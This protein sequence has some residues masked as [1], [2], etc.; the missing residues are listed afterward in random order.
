MRSCRLPATSGPHT[1][2]PSSYA[3]LTLPPALPGLPWPLELVEVLVTIMKQ[4][5]RIL[6]IQLCACSLLLR[7]LGGGGCR[8]GGDPLGQVGAELGVC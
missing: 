2:P 4:H 6:D 7:I 3:S 8:V 1:P 5:E